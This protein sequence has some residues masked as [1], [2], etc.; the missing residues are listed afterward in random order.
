MEMWQRTTAYNYVATF[1]CLEYTFFNIVYGYYT[2][3]LD[4]NSLISLQIAILAF[5]ELSVAAKK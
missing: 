5:C 3:S 2:I 4:F 1:F